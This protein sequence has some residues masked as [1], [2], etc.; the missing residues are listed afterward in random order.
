MSRVEEIVSASKLG[1]LI[2][3][4]Q[5]K[6]DNTVKILGI[7]AAAASLGVIAYL[8]Y[9]YFNPKFDLEDDFEDDF[10]DDL[11]DYDDDVFEDEKE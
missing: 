8:I 10:D 3:R 6:Q 2:N 7:V 1:E 5:K 9:R 4:K 11:T